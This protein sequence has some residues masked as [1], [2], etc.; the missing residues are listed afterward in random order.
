M[1]P[2]EKRIDESV[3]Y[4][5]K[6]TR[7]SPTI[8]LVLGSG[9]GDFA[10]TLPHPDSLSMRN[11][12]NYPNSAVEGH[13]G[14]LIFGILENRPL[15][16]FQ[17]RTHF[18]ESN[19]VQQVLY[20]IHIAHRLGVKK[21]II[22]NAAGG[23]NRSFEQG[24]LMLISDQIN[25][26]NGFVQ[27]PAT[28][29]GAPN[30]LYDKEMISIAVEV[31]RSN[32]IGKKKGIY[33]GVKGPSYETAAEVEMIHRIGG[34]AVGMSTVLEVSVANLIGM[35]VLG[36]SCITNYATGIRDAKLS[37]TEVTMV[38]NTVKQSLHALLSGIIRA[39]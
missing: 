17:G 28:E 15:L 12:P 31:G 9:L 39:I 19:S 32:Q 16:V 36:I 23:I 30:G 14:N 20:P 22:T 24:D 8:G 26:T 10:D 38:G 13:K 34:D 1:K 2:L 18:Y 35:K 21:L 4:I 37:H 33:A 5:L 6:R 11:I 25:L 7:I 3:S 29:L 27:H